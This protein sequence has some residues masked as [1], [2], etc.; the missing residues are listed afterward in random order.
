M[1]YSVISIA[2]LSILGSSI[3]S[4]NLGSKFNINISQ[5]ENPTLLT[6]TKLTS[7]TKL[8]ENLKENLVPAKLVQFEITP[9]EVKLNNDTIIEKESSSTYPIAIKPVVKVKVVSQSK[10]ANAISKSQARTKLTFTDEEMRIN[11]FLANDYL[12]YVDATGGVSNDPV[13]IRFNKERN[14]YLAKVNKKTTH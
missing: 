2:A 12:M 6:D 4:F 11:S 14:A 10:L 8:K 9:K 1:R 13:H 5:K 3:L 7:E